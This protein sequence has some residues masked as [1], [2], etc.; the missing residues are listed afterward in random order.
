MS[1]LQQIFPG[2]P[3]NLTLEKLAKVNVI[4][5]ED[6]LA[7]YHARHFSGT[8]RNAN[9]SKQEFLS[10]LAQLSAHKAPKPISAADLLEDT[11]ENEITL[12][13]GSKEL[14]EILSDGIPGRHLL[15]FAGK[16]G[17]FKTQLCHHLTA[18]ASTQKMNVVYFTTTNSFS[19]MRLG[20]IWTH[21]NPNQPS[22]LKTTSKEFE[23]FLDRIK[24]IQVFDV[25]GLTEGLRIVEE[26]LKKFKRPS[27]IPIDVDAEMTVESEFWSHCG[28]VVVDSITNLFLP[29]LCKTNK[30]GHVLLTSTAQKLKHLAHLYDLVVVTTNS[31]V[32]GE[33]GADMERPGLGITWSYVPHITVH[34]QQVDD[35]T[36]LKFYAQLWKA[37]NSAV[38]QP[39]KLCTLPC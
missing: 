3:H 7:L 36:P 29:V 34:L 37:T 19:V 13:S 26:K 38:K 9:V 10:L 14:D 21:M 28:L 11:L 30:I 31:T 1:R 32:A 22:P 2:P 24:P 15:E 6:V 18:Q 33:R 12:S 16:T 39:P 25:H 23:E 5:A 20:I 17:T 4:T 27:G 35:R 8:I